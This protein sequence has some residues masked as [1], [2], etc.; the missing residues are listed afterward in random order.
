[1]KPPLT[2]KLSIKATL[3]D[4][5]AWPGR[6]R[7][8][9]FTD[10]A[11]NATSH[12]IAYTRVEPALLAKSTQKPGGGSVPAAPDT[13]ISRDRRSKT[14]VPSVIVS[15]NPNS[16]PTRVSVRSEERRVGKE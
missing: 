14:Y 4:G 5:P 13:R 3:S 10:S 15:G 1:M 16:A 6:R 11:M 7:T 2:I 8:S 12:G 9:G